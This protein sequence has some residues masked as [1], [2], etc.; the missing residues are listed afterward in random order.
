MASAPMLSRPEPGDDRYVIQ[1]DAS[2]TGLGG[3]LTEA[4]DGQERVLEF[5]SRTLNSA[6]RNYSVCE[7]E[8][9]EVLWAVR[10]FRPYIEG[11][12]FKVITDHSSLKWLHNL[13]YPTGRS[14]R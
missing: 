5:S 4:I 9:L 14:A 8:C 11:Y 6:E 13:K 7:R 12:R 10:K 2:N 3:V 1:T